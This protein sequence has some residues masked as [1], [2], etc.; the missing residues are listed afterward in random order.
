MTNPFTYKGYGRIYVQNQ[1]DVKKVE[2]IIKQSDE[3]E[4]N[5]Y[6]ESLVTTID[7]YP[8]VVYVGKFE[9]NFNLEEECRKQNISVFVFDSG[10]E[11][12]PKGYRTCELSNKEQIQ[13][14]MITRENLDRIWTALEY[15]RATICSRNGFPSMEGKI[16]YVLIHK[17]RAHQSNAYL[18]QAINL[19]N[20]MKKELL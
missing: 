15:T 14:L 16:D 10:M 5:Y 2:D 6:P 18:E 20:K 7:R 8:D 9:L 1:E 11:N 12:W 3:F 19:V 17:G 4:W 13:N